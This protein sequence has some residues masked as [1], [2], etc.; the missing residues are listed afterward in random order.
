MYLKHLKKRLQFQ[1]TLKTMKKKNKRSL[2]SQLVRT[3]RKATTEKIIIKRISN[4][5][6]IPHNNN[7]Y[8]GSKIIFKITTIIV[9]I[10]W[11]NNSP[12]FP[13]GSLLILNIMVINMSNLNQKLTIITKVKIS[14]SIKIFKITVFKDS[15]KNSSEYL[16]YNRYFI[17]RTNFH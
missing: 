9:S 3:N 13:L 12:F 16:R 10:A 4:N 14:H 17:E 11:C 5:Y 8:N 6:Y 15:M 7:N 2:I 1:M